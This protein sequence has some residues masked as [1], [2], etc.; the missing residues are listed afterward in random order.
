MP[1]GGSGLWHHAW[2]A[3]LE[4]QSRA[5]LPGG[6]LDYTLR[7]SPRSRRL[8]LTVDPRRGVV[9]T[10]PARG[11]GDRRTRAAIESFLA[12]RERWLRRHLAQQATAAARA[13]S[14]AELAPGTTVRFRGEPHLV[15]FGRGAPAARRSTVTREGSAATD[16]LVIRLSPRDRRDP[17]SVLLAWLRERA[18][19]E[20]EREI[21]RHAGA[22]AVEP[23][24]VALRDQRT[25]WGSA[26]RTGRLA[27][28]WR[29]VLAPPEA[30]ETVVVH[31]LAHLR[32]F[33]H[34][35]DFWELVAS[36]RPDHGEWRRWLRRHSV[37]LHATLGTDADPRGRAG[38]GTAEAAAAS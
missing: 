24:A 18:R 22:L 5:L 19:S 33:G 3:V 7:A 20:I 13:T 25:R 32:V 35:P 21:E 30:L 12:E 10:I 1:P 8:R 16:E 9:V 27:F 28:S 31:E 38:E 23:V 29:L 2:V 34:G 37:E 26:T 15:R 4:T 36:R 14:R 17:A 6:H 11:A